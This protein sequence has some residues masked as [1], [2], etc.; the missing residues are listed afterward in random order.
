MLLQRRH[1][2]WNVIQGPRYL[3]KEFFFLFFFYS[4][5]NVVGLAVHQYHKRSTID[6]DSS[7]KL[8][9]IYRRSL[10]ASVTAG[11]PFQ[12]SHAVLFSLPK[13]PRLYHIPLVHG[14]LKH[15]TGT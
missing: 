15:G 8:H 7:L 3:G 6:M 4:T 2:R 11:K 14:T 5:H 13:M 9:G 1:R 10:T 12:I